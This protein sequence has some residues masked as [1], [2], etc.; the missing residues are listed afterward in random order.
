MPDTAIELSD[1]DVPNWTVEFDDNLVD[2][3][4]SPPDSLAMV[5]WQYVHQADK[6]KFRQ[7]L[8]DVLRKNASRT[9]IANE[10]VRD[11]LY[12]IKKVRATEALESFLPSIGNGYCVV[13]E[14]RLLYHA[15][16]VLWAL[17]PSRPV[18]RTT[19]QLMESRNFDERY[20]A[21]ATKIL[22]ECDPA[23]TADVVLRFEPRFRER[24]LSRMDATESERD[25]AR[26]VEDDWA[27]HML[28]FGPTSWLQAVWSAAAR[29]EEKRWV[30]EALF[31]NQECPLFLEPT[32][33]DEYV[34]CYRDVKSALRVS[35]KDWVTRRLA[36]RMSAE[37]S[38]DRWL[39]DPLDPVNSPANERAPGSEAIR[40]NVA[41]EPTSDGRGDPV[42]RIVDSLG[43][44]LRRGVSRLFE[45]SSHTI[46]GGSRG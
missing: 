44:Q 13:E 43:D 25:Y 30:F 7:A 22:V 24:R 23:S 4:V 41:S 36:L 31:R 40:A 35:D 11:L 42:P 8:G 27:S 26:R 34:L 19:R 18:R 45:N 2:I 39:S 10:A 9:L 21:A 17:A 37:R 1:V 38:L 14:P 12:L 15:L 16:T 6:L 20:L 29:A 32:A 5:Y 33:Q 3:D 28:R 46:P